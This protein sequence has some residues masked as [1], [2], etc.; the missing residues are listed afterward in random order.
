[1]LADGDGVAAALIAAVSHDTVGVE[2]AVGPHGQFSGGSGVAHSGDGLAQKV[3]AALRRVGSTLAQSS[4]QKVNI[5]RA[6]RYPMVL[7][8]VSGIIVGAFEPERWLPRSKQDFPQFHGDE[9]LWGFVGPEARIE[10]KQRY[11]HKKVPAE[12]KKKGAMA[13][14]KYLNPPNLNSAIVQYKRSRQ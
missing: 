8:H 10:L 5:Q 7:A 4:H 12:F 1:M 11:L 6:R 9:T 14:V 3:G 13:S 2:A